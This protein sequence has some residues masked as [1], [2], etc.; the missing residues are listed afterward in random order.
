MEETK[1]NNFSFTE[2]NVK[3][4]NNELDD[5]NLSETKKKEVKNY[6][7]IKKN[8]VLIVGDSMLNGN[9][10][11]KLSKTRHIRVQPFRVKK[12][13]ISKKILMIYYMKIYKR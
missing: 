13:M 5:S 4:I 11:S 10:E 6:R 2:E 7:K 8:N 9:K 12:L 1:S 3:T